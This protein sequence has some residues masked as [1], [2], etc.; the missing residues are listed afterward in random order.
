[1]SLHLDSLKVDAPQYSRATGVV[2]G[3]RGPVIHA[4]VPAAG[5]AHCCTIHTRCGRSIIAQVVS[6][7]EDQVHLS[8]LD[9]ID[10]VGPGDIVEASG[11]PISVAIGDWMRG[12]VVDALGKPMSLTSKAVS[13]ESRALFAAAPAALSRSH[14]NQQLCTGITS[15]DALNSLGLGQR[16]GIFA[17]AG[18][19]KSSLLGAIARN[20]S[21]DVNVIALVGERGREVKHFIEHILGPEGMARSCVVVATSDESAL[22][23]S[24]AA[25]T[26]TTIAEYFRDR[27]MNVLLLVDSLTRMARALRDVGL[28]SGELPVRQGYTPSVYA[29]LPRLLERAGTSES[30]SISALYTLLAD[31]NFESDPLAE[32]VKS[33]LDGHIVLS[34]R[35]AE[36][37]IRPAIDLRKSLSRLMPDLVD[38]TLMQAA[39]L[40][41]RAI[42][43]LQR[44][45]DLVLLG[46]TADAELTHL[47]KLEPNI[48]ASLN[49]ALNQSRTLEQS[50]ENII[51]LA[52]AIECDRSLTIKT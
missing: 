25:Y 2:V 11:S 5:L 14:I 32:E 39:E 36:E 44:E 21:A 3:V 47:I 49:Q 42:A 31:D 26:A 40:V 28:A 6:F 51:A 22:R 46:G 48:R 17:A 9:A 38:P 29:E 45:R 24:A 35:V 18:T 52:Q 1:M 43:R 41:R 4:R 12:C 8:A 37:G 15:I 16:I 23:R 33:I 30:G 10:G 13:A 34:R 19:G 50:R 7:S 27:G 20:T